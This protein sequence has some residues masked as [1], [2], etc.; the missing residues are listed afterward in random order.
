MFIRRK[1]LSRT[2]RLARVSKE[3]LIIKIERRDHH[4]RTNEDSAEGSVSETVNLLFAKV[5]LEYKP[6]K[7][8]GSLDA[9]IHFKYDIKGNKEG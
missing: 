5:D 8:D 4:Q 1:R 3:F 9:G 7:R 2:A 6:Q